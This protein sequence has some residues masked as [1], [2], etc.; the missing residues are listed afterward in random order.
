MSTPVPPEIVR[1]IL[2]DA[3]RKQCE[4]I[5]TENLDDVCNFRGN[6]VDSRSGYRLSVGE[7]LEYTANAATVIAFVWQMISAIKGGVRPSVKE[8]DVIVV[9]QCLNADKVP[10]EV[11][12]K[13]YAAVVESK[14]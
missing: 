14:H 9:A 12:T 8:I 7:A 2:M 3:M 6:Y 13:L 4:L 10:P 1:A 11:R 5:G